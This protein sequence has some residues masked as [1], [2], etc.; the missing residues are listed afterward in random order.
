M[1]DTAEHCDLVIVLATTYI[2]FD[3]TVDCEEM[4]DRDWVNLTFREMTPWER[5]QAV[6]AFAL[7]TAICL[8]AALGFLFVLSKMIEV[9][10]YR[11]EDYRRCMS[12]AQNGLEIEECKN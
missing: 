10:T 7:A 2:D 4:S 8:V 1:G 6:F 3:R 5:V 9:Q 11:I 12:K